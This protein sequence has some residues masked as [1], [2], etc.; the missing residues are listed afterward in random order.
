MEPKTRKAAATRYRNKLAACFTNSPA[1]QRE[2]AG[3]LIQRA[4]FLMAAMD[5]L[6]E[7]MQQEGYQQVYDN[8]GGQVGVTMSIALKS[9]N[10]CHQQFLSAMKQLRDYLPQGDAES[11][12]ELAQFFKN[13]S[14]K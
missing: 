10:A 12:D 13:S 7:D 4:A 3:F 14:K 5:E 2:A 11:Q 6:Q 1:E 8:G 9:Y